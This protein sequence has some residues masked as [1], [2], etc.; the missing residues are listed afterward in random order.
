MDAAPAAAER[1]PLELW[2]TG[3][4]DTGLYKITEFGI[5]KGN[6]N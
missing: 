2:H 1:L 3:G 5:V 6:F 4:G